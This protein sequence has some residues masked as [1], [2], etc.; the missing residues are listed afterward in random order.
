MPRGFKAPEWLNAEIQECY[1]ICEGNIKKIQAA[2]KEKRGIEIAYMTISDRLKRLGL[3]RPM[4]KWKQAKPSPAQEI[5]MSDE[6]VTV[7]A[8]QM[9]IEDANTPPP[10]PVSPIGD[11]AH[12]PEIT[13]PLSPAE[14]KSLEHYEQVIAQ[15]I[16]TF[17]EVG[18]ALYAIREQRL[19]R[20]DYGTFE[21][22]LRQRWDLSRPHAYRMIDAAKVMENL[23][24][25][26]DIVPVN[27]AQAR[28]LASLPPAQQSEA[29]KEAI[30][31]A[32]PTGIT[33]KHVQTTVKRVKERTTPQTQKTPEP[34]TRR[35]ARQEV[36]EGLIWGLREIADDDAWDM[37][38]WIWDMLNDKAEQYESL[39]GMLVRVHRRFPEEHRPGRM[40]T[41]ENGISQT[42]EV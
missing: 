33:A 1:P 27:E 22:Y 6:P 39:R 25:I 19:Y 35:P 2:I 41:G 29:W 9:S 20:Q 28:P 13:G 38:E 40:L 37:L 4:D 3:E 23:S 26:G 12:V 31:T 15:G 32:P 36:Q 30:E 18:Q 21:D 16:K 14:A 34:Q 42:S 5:P 10:E 11:I 17:V 8:G 24:P 7:L